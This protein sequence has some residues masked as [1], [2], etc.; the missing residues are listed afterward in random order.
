[1]TGHVAQR[2]EQTPR[3]LVSACLAGVP[4]RYD[5][6]SRPDAQIVAAVERGEAVALC[7]EQL[8]GLP[9]PR[10][11]AEIVGGDGADVL[12]GDAVVVTDAGEDVTAEFRDGAERVVGIAAS[13]GIERAILQARSPSCGCG[14]IYDGT[15]SGTLVGGDGIVAA[16]LRESGVHVT[17]LRGGT[18]TPSE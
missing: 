7:A 8:A 3:L 11:P 5:A 15:H 18:S 2:D 10:P 12:R 17:A 13:L 4:C 16:A 14:E 9:T 1:M 6:R